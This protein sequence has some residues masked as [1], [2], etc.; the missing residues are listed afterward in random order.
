MRSLHD[1]FVTN[2][3]QN[4]WNRL[5][6]KLDYV[7]PVKSFGLVGKVL[8][9]GFH[10]SE[11][12]DNSEFLLPSMVK[13]LCVKLK[14]RVIVFWYWAKHDNS[15]LKLSLPTNSMCHRKIPTS[16]VFPVHQ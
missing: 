1:P 3:C 7:F 9:Y 13:V 5:W 4:P 15:E 6:A 12:D 10:Y 14:L 16:L 11:K 2:L 8:S